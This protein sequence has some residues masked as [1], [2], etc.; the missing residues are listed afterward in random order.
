MCRWAVSRRRIMS[1]VGN[2]RSWQTAW[3]NRRASIIARCDHRD[4]EEIN[5][6]NKQRAIDSQIFTQL[7]VKDG[8]IRQLLEKITSQR[9]AYRDLMQVSHHIFII[10]SL[11]FTINQHHITIRGLWDLLQQG[12]CQMLWKSCSKNSQ[13]DKK[14]FTLVI[15]VVTLRQRLP[16]TW[17]SLSTENLSSAKKID[18]ESLQ[19]RLFICF[20]QQCV[21]LNG[22]CYSFDLITK[23]SNEI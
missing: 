18:S 1:W 5:Q 3:T 23:S 13:C 6:I 12:L 7:N 21:S 9:E 8:E 19:V 14:E 11:H 2:W 10:L 15:K 4:E 17:R 20:F 22:S 16:L